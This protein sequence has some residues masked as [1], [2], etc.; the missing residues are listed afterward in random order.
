MV[1]LDDVATS[2]MHLSAAKLKVKATGNPYL[3]A[4]LL[5]HLGHM[6]TRQRLLEHARETLNEADYV[7]IEAAQRDSKESTQ[8]YRA[9]LRYM[10]ERARFFSLTGWETSA[11]TMA[12]EALEMARGTGQ[13]DLFQEIQKLRVVLGASGQSVEIS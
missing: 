4:H 9:W 5:S 3:L 11:L 1:K 8:R 2:A 10:L 7:L 12:D 6:Q 13:F